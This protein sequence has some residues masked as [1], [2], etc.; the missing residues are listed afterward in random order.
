METL[1]LNMMSKPVH[2]RISADPRPDTSSPL[3]RQT[4]SISQTLHFV[5]SAIVLPRIRMP[6]RTSPISMASARVKPDGRPRMQTLPPFLMP[7]LPVWIVSFSP[8]VFIR[9]VSRPILR[10][11]LILPLI[12]SREARGA[13][14]LPILSDQLTP[15]ITAQHTSLREISM[16]PALSS[17]TVLMTI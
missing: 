15:Q 17:L 6:V 3:P 7:A 13:R 14:L 5:G 10:T 16:V 9:S 11:P 8:T 1:S 2:P 12:L 4:S